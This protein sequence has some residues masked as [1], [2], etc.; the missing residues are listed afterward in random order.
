MSQL[1]KTAL[2][3]YLALIIINLLIIMAFLQLGWTYQEKMKPRFPPHTFQH[4]IKL[5][6]KLQSTSQLQW[7]DI[8]RSQRISPLKITL[9]EKPYY[10]KNAV[11]KLNPGVII[12]LIRSHRKLEMSVFIS[13]NAWLNINLLSPYPSQTR[14]IVFLAVLLLILFLFI[15]YWAI[16]SLNQPIKTIIQS[17]ND[18]KIQDN[19][20]PIPITGNADQQAILKKINAL[21]SKLSKSLTNRTK[22]VAAIS[23]DLR[24]PL[25]RLKLRTE[26][27]ADNEHYEKIIQDINEMESMIRETLDYFRDIHDEEEPQR[28]DIVAMLNSLKEDAIEMNKNVS[29]KT[30]D[31]K[32][33]CTGAVNL[34]KRAFSNVINN[35][36]YYGQSAYIEL[37]LTSNSMVEIKI[38]DRGPGLSEHDLD[39]VFSAFYRGEESRSRTTGGSGLGLTIA[40]E[41]IQMHQGTITLSNL[42]EGGLKVTIQLPIQVFM[43]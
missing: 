1:T 27:L 21:Q 26:Y 20:S 43:T 12:D 33:I 18:N 32:I 16:R 39:N 24:T 30:N 25:T 2:K 22:V 3:T 34:L 11:L 40:K 36:L 31:K 6:N 35:A 19:W 10:K 37:E 7:P 17:L 23:H 4:L 41:I 38:T 13:E 15:N 5:T 8:L 9:S 14:F 42:K 29:F 28:F